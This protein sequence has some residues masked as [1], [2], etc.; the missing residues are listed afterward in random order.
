MRH[1]NDWE[2]IKESG[3]FERL[4]PGGYIVKI[5][6]VKDFPEKEYLKISFDIAEGDKKGFFKKSFDNDTRDQKKWPNGGSFIRSYKQTAASMFK[7]FVSAVEASN[8]GYTF[9]F[10]EQTLVGKVV[11]L[12]LGDE[13]FLNQKGQVRTRTYVNAVR[14]VEAIK[15][16]D[17]KIPE[18]K[19]LDASKATTAAATTRSAPFV[20]PFADGP[21]LALAKTEETKTVDEFF[22]DEELP[23]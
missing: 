19:K 1:I 8:K 16:G 4:A 7:G 23:F 12:V 5:L 13:E 9:D 15:N 11:G 20:D 22:T 3:T 10:D 14:S 18:L 6:N 2:N 21:S 17:Y